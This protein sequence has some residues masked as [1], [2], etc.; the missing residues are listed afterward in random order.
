ML[1]VISYYFGPLSW[2]RRQMEIFSMSLALCEG[3]PP[4][5]GGF[6][7]QRPVT[8]SFAVFFDLHLSKRLKK[9]LRLQWFET[10]PH[11]LW[12]HCYAIIALHNCTRE[13]VLRNSDFQYSMTIYIKHECFLFLESNQLLPVLLCNPVDYL[14]SKA[15]WIRLKLALPSICFRWVWECTLMS[16][17]G[18][19]SE[20]LSLCEGFPLSTSGF[21]SWSIKTDLCY[22]L[23]C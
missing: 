20:L 13:Q 9:Q 23:C 15:Y 17:L 22:L 16:L 6:P 19:L 7:S 21:P 4:A 12:R 14:I 1:Y 2:W 3:N 5:T 11:S 8:W 18:K 10:P